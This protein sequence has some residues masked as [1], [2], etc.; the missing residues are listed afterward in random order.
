MTSKPRIGP[1]LRLVL[2]VG[3]ILSPFARPV[4]KRR[5]AKGKEDPDRWLEKLG[6]A[7]LPRPDGP[8]VWLHGVGVGEV[9]ALRGLIESLAAAR[10]DLQFLVTSSARSSGEVFANNLPAKTRHQYLPLD[11]PKPVAAFLDH[12]K[13]DL[14]VWSDQ[15]IW[16]RL[17]VTSARRAIPQAYIAARITEKS[18]KAK[19]RFGA[20]YGDLYR[21]L[22][23]RH[24]QDEDTATHLRE[25]MGD[26]SKVQVT[27]SLKVPELVENHTEFEGPAFY[28]LTFVLAMNKAKYESL[29]DDLRAALDAESGAALSRL[30]ATKMFAADAPGRAIAVKKGNNIAVL[31]EAEVARWKK[32]SEPVVSQWIADMEGRGIDGNALIARAKE[33]I[34]ANAGK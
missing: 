1:M 11:L 18:A 2:G 16:P 19:A 33:L 17:A 26:D 29:P 6:Q 30:A 23:L 27:G 32:A 7:S 31:D 10:P 5:L 21:L 15:E 8:L 22:D 20:A 12:W 13:P 4:L 28:N 14:A 34:A 24:A 25:L 3:R 9:M